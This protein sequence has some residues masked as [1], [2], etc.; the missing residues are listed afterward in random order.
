[1]YSAIT[2]LAVLHASQAFS[3]SKM[4]LN[5]IRVQ[6]SSNT[7][8]FGGGEPASSDSVKLP[9]I[10]GDI[11]PDAYKTQAA[12]LRYLIS[13]PDACLS[14]FDRQEAAEMEVALREEARA[15]GLPEEMINKLV[16]IRSSP[17][18]VTSTAVLEAPT[19]LK[20]SAAEIRKKLG[21]LNSGDAVRFTSELD[22]LQSKRIVSLWNSKDL[23]N[24]SKSDFQ[25][26]NALL[27]RRTNIDSVNL[28]LDDVGYKYQYVLVG[29]VV[30]GT[31]FG[32]AS[33]QLGGQLG[34]LLGYA[35]ALVPIFIVGIGSI[36]PALI[37]DAINRFRY[38]TDQTARDK[39]ILQNAA[40]FLVGYTCG[41][42]VS[43]FTTGGPSNVCEFFQIRP[44][45]K[46]SEKRPMFSK[47]F[48]EPDIARAAMTCIASNV[49]E[50]LVY[51]EASGTTASD[52]NLLYELLN[53][54]DPPMKPEDAQNYIRWAALNAHEILSENRPLLT[55]LTELFREGASLEDCIAAVEESG[56]K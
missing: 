3:V 51:G 44:S 17:S 8:L 38:A 50:C 46:T 6:A 33:S 1:M 5:S 47:R 15:K 34:F 40:K 29:A 20:L 21:Y 16:P 24:L 19:Q 22:R 11:G 10:K 55:K 56:D 35:S 36:A 52:V 49:G 23:S 42:P 41:L 12:R 39:Y 13:I 48:S 43:R 53:S 30:F 7:D 26:S 37:G 28:R 4:N 45:E 31:I 2:I 32:L 18:E 27:T 14:S 54:V 25:V 9:S